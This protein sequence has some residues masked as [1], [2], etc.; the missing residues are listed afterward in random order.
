MFSPQEQSPMVDDKETNE[1]IEAR[2]PQTPEYRQQLN[3]AIDLMLSNK[4]ESGFPS[5]LRTINRHLRQYKLQDRVSPYEVF[6]EACDRAFKK[7]EKGEKIPNIP[8]WFRT[9]C[10]NIIR[11]WSRD[12]IRTDGVNCSYPR[13][14]QNSE[15]EQEIGNYNPNQMTNL[16]VLAMY[17]MYVQLSKLDQKVLYLSASGLSWEEIADRL[18]ES[19]EQSG[20]RSHVSQALAKRASR[21][22]KR[23]RQLYF[24]A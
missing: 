16:D 7:L 18:I 2:C 20:D 10:F 15:E 19:G 9:T 3:R 24:Y 22:R 11:E 12:T 17:E 8:P 1:T 6:N 14:D 4:E 13:D 5:I 23:L 21:S